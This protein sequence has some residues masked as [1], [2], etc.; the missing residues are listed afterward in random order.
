MAVAGLPSLTLSS[1]NSHRLLDAGID[2]GEL[3]CY[4]QSVVIN[5][6]SRGGQTV[7]LLLAMDPNH[8]KTNDPTT[9]VM[10]CPCKA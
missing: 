10:K 1:A 6:D 4:N 2:V 9:P 5:G 3:F 7:T 8:L